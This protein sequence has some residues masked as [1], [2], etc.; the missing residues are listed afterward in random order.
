[1]NEVVY[2]PNDKDAF[3]IE[4]NGKRIAEMIIGISGNEMSV[5]HTEVVKELKGKGI[6]SRMVNV[7]AEHAR[8]H[9][10]SVIPL[11]PFVKEHFIKN[12]EE[13]EDVWKKDM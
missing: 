2:K 3:I 8:N 10:L 12:R 4:E 11:C 13:Y 6:G 1:M 9:N 7:M 5:Y